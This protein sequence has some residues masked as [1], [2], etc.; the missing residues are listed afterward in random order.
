MS[1]IKISFVYFILINQPLIAMKKKL[2]TTMMLT[3]CIS[4]FTFAQ[5]EKGNWFLGGS[6]NLK[7]ASYKEKITS[8]GTTVENSKNSNFDFRP[9]VGY[10]VIDK[11][12]VGI[13]MDLS[14]NNQKM[15][16]TDGEY[17]WTSFIVGPFVRYYI[18]NL[19]GFMP[20]AEASIGFGSG[21][22]KETYMSTSND[23]KY[24]QLSY[25]FGVGGTYFVTDN[26]GIDLF[27]G[28]NLDQQTY[29][30][31]DAAARATNDVI[32]KYGGLA[33][34]LGFVITMGK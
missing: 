34:N 18:A 20:F 28:Y 15:T 6:S 12:P 11:L 14:M 17:K 8:G 10:F 1:K 26:V 7:F 27:L 3:L 30:E 9:Q 24:K 23:H 25:R 16:N 4:A 19:S 31:E 29:K 2:F 21:N 33:V 5:V 32:Y 13:L 22:Y